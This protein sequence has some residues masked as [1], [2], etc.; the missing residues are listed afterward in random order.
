M[1][2][3]VERAGVRSVSLTDEDPLRLYR[4]FVTIIALTRA[5]V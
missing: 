3:R 5:I 4:S 2:P 1:D